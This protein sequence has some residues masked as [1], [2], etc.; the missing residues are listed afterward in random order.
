MADYNTVTAFGAKLQT[1]QAPNAAQTNSYTGF[2]QTQGNLLNSRFL[3]DSPMA[4]PMAQ[5]YGGFTGLTL[6]KLLDIYTVETT[7]S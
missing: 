3:G 6:P 5:K 2:K 7:P 4:S 1:Q